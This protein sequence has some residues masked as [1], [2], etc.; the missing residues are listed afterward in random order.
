M[1]HC[2]CGNTE[3]R[4]FNTAYRLCEKCST[5]VSQKGLSDE[6][7]KVVDDDQDFYGKKY[8][9]EHQEQEFGYPDLQTRARS[10][11]TERNLHWLKSLL[12]YCLP[13]AR[14]MELG[15]A[16][17]SFVATLRQAGYDAFGVE[18][19][20]WLIDYGRKTFGVSIYL[21]PVESLEIPPGSLDV[22]ALMDVLEHLPEP[23]STMGQCLK[24]LK[25]D[26]LLL[27]QTPQFKSSM[28]YETL[29]ESGGDF[30]QQLKD[31]EHI[32]LFSDRSITQLFRR[33]GA[34]HIQFELAVFGH[35]DMFFAVSRAPFVF[36]SVKAIDEA[37]TATPQGR[38]ALALLDIYS[39]ESSGV[40]ELKAD[41]AHLIG[42]LEES[43]ADRAARLEVIERQGEQLGRIPQ[44]EADKAHLIGRL[45]ESEADRAARLEVIERQGEQLGRIP[46]LEADKAHLIGRLEESEADRAARLEVIERQ[47]KELG[48]IHQ[49]EADKA[50]LIGRLEETEKERKALCNSKWV[51]VGLRLG[52]V[53]TKTV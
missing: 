38:L 49:L 37:L 11:L 16:H 46:Q 20:P 28:R 6:Q 12:K 18:M 40:A 5:L 51:R 21:G 27:V 1:R 41:K 17:G 8:W 25:P 47:G 2:W 39:R 3:L 45:E 52:L 24:L 19:S 14:V 34:D 36:H 9:A 44:L 15:C 42:R 4:V 7:L 31:E 13:P 26:G 53:S 33:L 35:Y 29:L 32:Y 50:H 43:E 23:V 30:L 22:I 10:D 48:R